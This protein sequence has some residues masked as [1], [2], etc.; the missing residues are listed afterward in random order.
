MAGACNYPHVKGFIRVVKFD[1]DSN[2]FLE[3]YFE[4]N[5]LFMESVIDTESYDWP[6]FAN[7]FFQLNPRLVLFDS[8]MMAQSLARI[9]SVALRLMM[10]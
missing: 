8:F 6:D 2:S 5:M 1:I 3:N 4:K 9:S 7:D 10:S